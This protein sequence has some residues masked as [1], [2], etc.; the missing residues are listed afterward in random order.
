MR[1]YTAQKVQFSQLGV[2]TQ[3]QLEDATGVHPGTTLNAADLGAAAQ[4]LVDTG[5]FDDVSAT[6]EGKISAATIKLN[7]K[8][9]DLAHLLPVGYA[10]FVWLT[11]DE[12]DT[13]VRA[14]IPLYND[15]L[16]ENSPREEEVRMILTAAL[17]AKSVKAEVA[18]DTYEPTLRHPRRAIAFR[19]TQPEVR[20][21]NVKLGGVTPAL[22]P[23]VQKSVNATVRTAYEEGPADRT[24][25]DR[26]LE[27]LLNAGYVQAKLIDRMPT[28]GA[29]ESGTVPVVLAARLQAGKVYTV[30]S[31]TFAG[32]PMLS[33]EAFAAT[34]KLHGGDV[35]SREDLL[36]TLAPLDAAY[37]RKGYLN[38]VVEVVPSF[39][40]TADTVAY[41]VNVVPGEQYRVHEVSAG[42]LDPAAKADFDRGWLME[43]GELYN[44]EYVKS[45]LKQNT[46]LQALEGYA[47]GFKA[48]A[49]PNTHTVDL[50]ITFA[51][52]GPK[53]R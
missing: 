15:Y 33:A 9:T 14:K 27:P 38:V 3:Q 53:A 20:V 52:M 11:R 28:P 21:A 17:S 8:P 26:I 5:Y 6:I 35:A 51:R 41:T 34:A 19:V 23:L 37:R 13:A 12:I 32:T 39:D 44:P 31:V 50:V 40:A 24:S 48:Y 43:E 10:N 18:F 1:S 4:R 16:P 30:A 36:A 25:E 42:G 29:V 47:A 49:D 2:F 45:F 46:A 7:T 22:V